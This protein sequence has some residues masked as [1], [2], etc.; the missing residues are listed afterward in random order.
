MPATILDGKPVAKE[1]EEQVAAGARELAARG[2][3]VR[4]VA[5]LVGL[6]DAAR[7]YAN[8]QGRRA[9][10]VGIEYELRELGPATTQQEL[11]ALLANLNADA[12]V[13]GLIVQM[14]VPRQ[15]DPAVVQRAIAPGKDVEG[16]HPENMGRLFTGGWLV[17]P[18]TPLAAVELLRRACPNLAGK[19]AVVVGR[20]TIV[21]KPIAVM[22]EHMDL[23][24]TVTVCHSK[25]RDLAAHCRRAEVLVAATGYS[26]SAWERYARQRASGQTPPRPDL[27]PLI[28]ADMVSPGAVVI[29]VATN[30]VP[31]GFDDA[32]EPL[33]DDKGQVALRAMGDVDYDGVVAKVAAI[34]PV[35]GGVGPVTVAMLLRNTLACARQAAG[36]T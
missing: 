10:A 36:G 5:I 26:Q 8:M 17:A 2:R 35:P 11:L 29:D 1:I 31:K 30:Y 23:S 19:E 22:L 3:P 12:S 4:L 13:S 24:A 16:V 15:I 9:K 18:C 7:W 27:A 32:G 33:K 28:K 20:S 6:D 34:T 25:T 21:G 14:P